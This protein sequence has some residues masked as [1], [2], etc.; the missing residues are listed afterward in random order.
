MQ[1]EFQF[2]ASGERPDGLERWRRQRDARVDALA[3]SRGIPLGHPCRVVLS[4]HVELEGML[5]L[6]E[7]DLLTSDPRNQELRLRIGRCIFTSREIVSVVR[8]D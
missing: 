8:L 5:T 6:A 3:K 4:G 1:G 7:E 2:G